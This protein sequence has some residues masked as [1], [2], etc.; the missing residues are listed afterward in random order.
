MALRQISSVLL[1]SVT[2]GTLMSQETGLLRRHHHLFNAVN[3][4]NTLK[5]ACGAAEASIISRVTGCSTYSTSGGRTPTLIGSSPFV[6]SHHRISSQLLV[7]NIGAFRTS[8]STLLIAPDP[9]VFNSTRN[10]IKMSMRKGRRKTVKAVLNR[11]YRLDWGAWISPKP[12][13]ARHLWKKSSRRR[14]RLRNHIFRKPW[15]NR[16]LEKM[17]T[18][19]WVKKKYFVDDPYETFHTRDNFPITKGV[20]G[21]KST[22]LFQIKQYNHKDRR[23]KN[24]FR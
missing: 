6:S 8:P 18:K 23:R 20:Q 11:F 7:G 16:V 4:I 15:E 21:I 14:H 10:V 12:G 19:Y 1:R 3:S 2:P 22:N 13:R 9:L 24:P 5:I 17:M